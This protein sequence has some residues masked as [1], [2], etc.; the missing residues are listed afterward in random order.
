MPTQRWTTQNFRRPGGPLVSG[1]HAAILESDEFQTTE[2]T[3]PEHGKLNKRGGTVQQGDAPDAANV[4]WLMRVYGAD[5]SAALALTYRFCNGKLQYLT[6]GAWTNFATGLTATTYPVAVSYKNIIWWVDGVNTPT[7]ITIADPP[8]DSNW[9]TLPSGI[10][11]Q[12][13]VLHKNRLYYGGDRSTPTYVYMTNPGDPTT[14]GATDFYQVP[15]DQRGFF[16]RIAVDM[17]DGIGFFAQDYKCFMTG[18][19]PLSHRIY[20]FEKAQAALYWRTVVSMGDCRAIYLTEVGPF[21]WDGHSTAVPLDPH[22]RQNWGDMDLTT[23]ET[24][25]AVRYGD[26]WVC[27]YKKKGSTIAAATGTA[28]QRFSIVTSSLNRYDIYSS[29]GTPGG[30]SSQSSSYI[31]YNVRTGQWTQGEMGN[32][33]GVL[34]ACWEESLYGDTQ[35]LWVG[36][37]TTGG[38]VGKFDQVGTY[39]DFTVPYEM[40]VRT[41]GIG[42]QWARTS[43]EAVKIKASVHKAETSACTVSVYSNGSVRDPATWG[44]I[45]VSLSAD[46]GLDGGPYSG[47][48]D[49]PEDFVVR[50]IP[51]PYKGQKRSGYSPQIEFV[52]STAAFTSIYSIAADFTSEES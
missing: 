15:D 21:I 8:V 29:S 25:H 32:G 11:P 19:G 12:W 10:N 27:W 40:R 46:H 34:C 5:S 26:W 16:P 22:G 24:T 9:T 42:D 6:G 35:D 36:D 47:G 49:T 28:R 23:N 39:T 20:Q 14:T 37:A 17:G 33:V 38:K 52:D 41:A 30:G 51:S 4:K 2:N 48:D 1:D 50:T 3:W 43:I 31:A 45:D 13:V 7:Q 44:P 18:T